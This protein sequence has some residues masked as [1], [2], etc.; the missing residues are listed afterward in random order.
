MILGVTH[1]ELQYYFMKLNKYLFF[2]V[3]AEIALFLSP[4]LF[5]LQHVYFGAFISSSEMRSRSE[6]CKKHVRYR[7][8]GKDSTPSFQRPHIGWFLAIPAG[9]LALAMVASPS[10]FTQLSRN[11]AIDILTEIG[12][13][14]F[15]SYQNLRY[16]FLVACALHVGE[17]CVALIVCIKRG[18]SLRNILLWTLQTMLL[19]FPSLSMLLK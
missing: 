7:I 1:A 14:L 15:G 5:L 19:G 10:N 16:V 17:S 6:A 11:W 13:K 12:L 8:V 3:A 2:H 18:Y 4:I 9:M